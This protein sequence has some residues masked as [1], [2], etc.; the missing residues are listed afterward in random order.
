MSVENSIVPGCFLGQFDLGIGEHDHVAAAGKALEI[1]DEIVVRPAYLSIP[2]EGFDWILESLL[3]DG[4]D[5]I[6]V[7]VILHYRYAFLLGEK[8]NLS[9]GIPLLE[10]LNGGCGEEN[11]TYLS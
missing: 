9:I 1:H 7:G 3:V 5:V 10:K 11:I 4:P 8:I 2:Q 6:D